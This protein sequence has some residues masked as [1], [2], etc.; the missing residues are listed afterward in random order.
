MEQTDLPHIPAVAA[1]MASL[2]STIFL[3]RHHVIPGVPMIVLDTCSTSRRLSTE[4]RWVTIMGF[5]GSDR[6]L[7]KML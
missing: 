4:S 7:M 5:E 2:L 1:T 3:C 6:H